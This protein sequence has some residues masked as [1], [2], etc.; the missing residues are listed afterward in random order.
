MPMRDD[1]LWVYEGM[2]QYWGKV[3]T[4]RSGMRTAGGDP[5]HA[6]ADGRRF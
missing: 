1:L 4:A 3:L 5:G 6:G 2:T